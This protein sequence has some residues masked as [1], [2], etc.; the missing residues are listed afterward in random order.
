MGTYVDATADGAGDELGLIRTMAFE[1]EN[2]ST[3]F[4]NPTG[5]T[6]SGIRISPVASSNAG[7]VC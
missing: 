1:Y 2:D 7:A 3:S 6:V 5:D 4:F